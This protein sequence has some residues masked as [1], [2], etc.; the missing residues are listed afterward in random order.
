[1]LKK[2]LTIAGSDCS[3]GA[4]IQADLKTFSA[5][6]TYGMSCICALTAQNTKEVSMVENISQVMITAQL[7]A[8]YDDIVP[9]AVK[10]G[11]LSTAETVDTV[12]TFLETLHPFNLVV[13]PVMVATSGARLLDEDA[14]HLYRTKLIPLASVVTPNVP[15]AEVLAGMKIQTIEDMKQ[16]ALKIMEIGPKAV[17]IKGGHAVQTATDVLYNGYEFIVYEEKKIETKNTHGTG[18]TLSS[19]I[20]ALLAQNYSLEE[21]VQQAKSYLTGAIKAAALH[22]PGHGYGPVSHFWFYKNP[23]R[24]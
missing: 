8:I 12:S 21:A 22:S 14:V 7:R 18:C 24:K 11:M 3:G 17:L 10:T 6:G 19:A 2:C 16:A 23:W 9:D 4:G 15:E 20:A 5:L 13:D 1:M